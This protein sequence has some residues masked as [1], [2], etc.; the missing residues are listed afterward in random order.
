MLPNIE[1]S[2]LSR[3]KVKVN[4]KARLE[5]RKVHLSKHKIFDFFKSHPSYTFFQIFRQ[6]NKAG[7]VLIYA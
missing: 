2:I 3:W 1:L 7:H 4:F 5:S 6:R